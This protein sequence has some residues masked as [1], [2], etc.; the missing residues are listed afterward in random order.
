MLDPVCVFHG[1]RLSE[2]ECLYC[3]ICFQT[4]TRDECWRDENGQAWDLCEA[5][6]RAERGAA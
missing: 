6:G 4:L 1:K 3:C 2:H 5:C